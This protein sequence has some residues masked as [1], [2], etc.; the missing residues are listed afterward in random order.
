MKMAR[1]RTISL[2]D[3][4]EYFAADDAGSACRCHWPLSRFS[5]KDDLPANAFR[6]RREG[7]PLRTFPDH[8]LLIGSTTFAP[9]AQNGFAVVRFHDRFMRGRNPEMKKLSN[10]SMTSYA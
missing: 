9:K 6:V 2:Q 3:P 4:D 10:I 7:K 5:S 8:A 1:N